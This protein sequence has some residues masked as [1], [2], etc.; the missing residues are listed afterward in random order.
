M[1]SKKPDLRKL[2]AHVD[3]DGGNGGTFQKKHGK[4]DDSMHLSAQ[5][6]ADALRK[7]LGVQAWW[8][9]ECMIAAHLARPEFGGIQIT[10][11]NAFAVPIIRPAGHSTGT[12]MGWG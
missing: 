7:P 1:V 12:D 6:N 5:E 11:D 10:P 8:G 3:A 2:K 4:S 9:T